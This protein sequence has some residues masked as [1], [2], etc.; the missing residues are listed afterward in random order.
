MAKGKEVAT[1][2]NSSTAVV[3]GGSFEDHAGAGLE[4]VGAGDLLIPR[5]GILQDLSPQVKPQKAEF[6]EGAAIG[7][8]CD[9][10][11]GDLFTDGILFLPV[12]Y[13][14][15]YLEWYPR[16]TGKGLAA[17]HSDPAILDACTRDE[18]NRPI[19]E[20]G[21]L[22]SETAQMFGFNLTADGR[23]SFIPMSST[24]LKKSKKWLTLATGEKLTRGDGST[25][26]P[27]LFYRA[28][29]LTTVGESNNDGDWFGWKVERGP[30][31]PDLGE[32][33]AGL[34]WKDVMN[35]AISFRE[36]LVT[37]GANADVSHLQGVEGDGET[38]DGEAM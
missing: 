27:P 33:I 5:I 30:A 22:V 3:A 29:A 24:Q 17:I 34:D 18:R 10:G 14:K 31:L 9:I 13:R 12:Y 38:I 6:I 15:D 28:Y 4:N 37:G 16:N 8:I 35:E 1:K 23:K 20:N 21:N 25:Y 36:S 2:K 11:T 7:N 19:L 32:T 26:T